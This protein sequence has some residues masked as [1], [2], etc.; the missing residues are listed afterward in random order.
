MADQQGLTNSLLSIPNSVQHRLQQKHEVSSIVV[1][2]VGFLPATLADA[3]C[4]SSACKTLCCC[5]IVML[6]KQGD[7]KSK[8]WG[9]KPGPRGCAGSPLAS[10]RHLCSCRRSSASC[11]SLQHHNSWSHSLPLHSFIHS[12]HH[13]LLTHPLLTHSPP[14]PPHYTLMYSVS[15]YP[16]ALTHSLTHSHSLAHRTCAPGVR[17]PYS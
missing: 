7:Q 14:D 6:R 5:C 15:P 3:S 9:Q 13:P 10:M 11:L 16:L 12:R 17:H 2:A 1:A 8:S 4:A